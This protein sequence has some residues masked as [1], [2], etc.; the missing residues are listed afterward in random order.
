[1][2]LFYFFILL[3]Q[4]EKL[5]NGQF[6]EGLIITQQRKEITAVITA[7][8]HDQTAAADLHME[9]IF[10]IKYRIENCHND[11]LEQCSRRLKDRWQ[12][13]GSVFPA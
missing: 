6:P 13:P 2:S 1:M 3:I 5:G 8:G 10:F 9:P 11:L 12:I 4:P 7:Y